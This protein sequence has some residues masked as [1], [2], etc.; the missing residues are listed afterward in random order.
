[1]QLI[2]SVIFVICNASPTMSTLID[3]RYEQRQINDCT[4]KL[5]EAMELSLR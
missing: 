2:L 4:H 1:M 5:N 3:W